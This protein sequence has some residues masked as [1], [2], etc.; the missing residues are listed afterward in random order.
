MSV[1]EETMENPHILFL[2]SGSPWVLVATRILSDA[3]LKV[4]VLANDT[5]LVSTLESPGPDL[6]L[7]D[8]A[9]RLAGARPAKTPPSCW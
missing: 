8:A 6:L 3:G 9:R 7:I 2:T 5:D 1:P 4:E